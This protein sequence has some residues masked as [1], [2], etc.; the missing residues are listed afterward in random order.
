VSEDG[1]EGNDRYRV[2]LWPAAAGP[3]VTIKAH[4]T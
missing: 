1:L 2:V 4:V 3:T